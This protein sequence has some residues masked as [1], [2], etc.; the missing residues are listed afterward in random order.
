MALQPGSFSSP[1][2][3]RSQVTDPHHCCSL[4]DSRMATLR[5]GF[6]PS[7]RANSKSTNYKPQPGFDKRGLDPW[8][9]KYLVPLHDK[10][11]DR[12]HPE[13]RLCRV[14]EL[15]LLT[16]ARSCSSLESEVRP[17]HLEPSAS[18]SF[19]SKYGVSLPSEFLVLSRATPGAMIGVAPPKCQIPAN[20]QCPALPLSVQCKCKQQPQERVISHSV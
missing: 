8:A 2:A 14:K 9:S 18:F 19:D 12:C 15:E 4:L 20:S 7:P 10:L 1:Q 5:G 17:N 16:P 3:D 11:T 13:S 6:P